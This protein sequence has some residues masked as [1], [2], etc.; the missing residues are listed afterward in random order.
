MI[1]AAIIG[2]AGYTAGELIRILLSHSEAEIISVASESHK[3]EF[4][5]KAHPDLEGETDLKFEEEISSG[6]DVVFI[7]SGHG[8]S[9]GAIESGVIPK[10]AK[11]IDLSSDFRIKSNNHDFVYGLPELNREAIK[12][13]QKVANPG[14]FATCIQLSLLPLAQAGLL[15]NPVHITAITGSTGAGQNPT[16]T[17]HYSWRSNNA[18]VYKP[19]Q[20]QHLGEILHSLKQLQ[21][22]FEHEIHFI[23]MRGAFTRGILSACYLETAKSEEEVLSLFKSYYQDHPF[24]NISATS[25]DLK[26]VVNT[27]K[28]ILHMQ[29]IG[30][31]VL[32]TGVIDNLLKGASGQAVQNMNLMFGLDET[33][34]LI[35]KSTA[36]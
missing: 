31:Q 4:L 11:I 1:K 24:V 35:F 27:N 5:H 15:K 26:R 3:G 2:G 6:A 33:T 36:F 30:N 29:K 28:A 32:I 14:C 23:P 9:K 19:F 21:N 12:T 20:H 34:G 7:C 8:K 17:T 10:T 25:P 16:E 22:N 18:S 13:A